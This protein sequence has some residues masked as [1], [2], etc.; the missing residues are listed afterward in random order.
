MNLKRL[1]RELGDDFVAT[2]SGKRIE[3]LT[4]EG[5]RPVRFTVD[6]SWKS[7]GDLAGYLRSKMPVAILNRR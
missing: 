1:Q 2:R 5:R 4:K 6:R 3:V 7:E